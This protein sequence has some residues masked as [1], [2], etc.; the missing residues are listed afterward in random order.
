MPQGPAWLRLTAPDR[1]SRLPRSSMHQYPALQAGARVALIAPAGPLRLPEDLDRA[2]Q[3]VRAFGWE[4]R[5]GNNVEA[6]SD[7]F[8]GTD[9]E[10]LADLNDAIRDPDIDAIW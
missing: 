4:P 2:M 6:R 10:R 9:A 1:F 5:V 7:Y 3:N 8:A